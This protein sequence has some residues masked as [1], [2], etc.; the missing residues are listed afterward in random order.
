MAWDYI[1]TVLLL[2]TIVS[3][4]SGT[5]YIMYVSLLS[6]SCI[7]L[8]FPHF[9]PFHFSVRNMNHRLRGYSNPDDVVDLHSRHIHH[10]YGGI[11]TF[12]VNPSPQ[13]RLQDIENESFC[14]RICSFLSLK[15][16]NSAAETEGDAQTRLVVSRRQPRDQ[17]QPP[18]GKT[19][20]DPFFLHRF[21]PNPHCSIMEGLNLT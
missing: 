15:S 4:S 9:S 21:D 10:F 1:P 6:I 18:P 20:E 17:M 11:E 3:R 16:N 2:F 19:P 12:P 8:L 14:H 5:G 13:S 7:F